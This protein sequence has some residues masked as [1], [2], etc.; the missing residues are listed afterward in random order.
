MTEVL[1]VFL[2]R[3]RRQ[4]L[5]DQIGRIGESSFVLLHDR[6]VIRF[7]IQHIRLKYVGVVEPYLGWRSK[8]DTTDSHPI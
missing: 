8:R 4:H 5:H 6:K 3:P 2:R 1:V 7:D